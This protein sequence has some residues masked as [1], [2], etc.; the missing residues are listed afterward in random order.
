MGQQGSCFVSADSTPG[1]TP[2]IP[3][4]VLKEPRPCASS[5]TL[6][7]P[8]PAPV[9]S[10]LLQSSTSA[11]CSETS[12]GEAEEVRP[13]EVTSDPDQEAEPQAQAAAA[14][15]SET[16]EEKARRLLYCSLCKVA[17][18]SASQLEAH[19]S[20]KRGACSHFHSFKSL[21]V[22][23]ISTVERCFPARKY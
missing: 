22:R 14:A 6:P 16:E 18:N 15:D 20:G 17:V 12:A 1:F 2:L 8:S 13:P 5:V 11:T 10:P 21:K 23:L 3:S 9:A 19:N 4:P 7:T